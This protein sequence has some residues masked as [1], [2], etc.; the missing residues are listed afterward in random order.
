MVWRY[1][2][3]QAVL[4][5]GPVP[6]DPLHYKLV[7]VGPVQ[8]QLGDEGPHSCTYWEQTVTLVLLSNRGTYCALLQQLKH[9][10]RNIGNKFVPCWLKSVKQEI[11]MM[12]SNIRLR[13]CSFPVAHGSV[14]AKLQMQL[15]NLLCFALQIFPP[16]FSQ[17]EDERW[18]EGGNET[19]EK[20][21]TRATEK[22]VS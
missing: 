5:S 7:H 19:T 21:A 4:W 3:Q 14:L 12:I 1:S 11:L 2:I 15:D 17:R 8:A 18:S 16:H 20:T 6:E 10:T 13:T 22:K 9:F